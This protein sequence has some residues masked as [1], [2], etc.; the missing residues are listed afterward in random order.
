MRKLFQQSILVGIISVALFLVL[1]SFAIKRGGDSYTISVNGKQ[2]V[3]YFVLSKETLPELKINANSQDKLSVYYS[4]CGKIGTSRKL[5]VRNN[6]GQ[7]IKEWKFA[8]T[9]DE[10]TPMMVNAKEIIVSDNMGLYYES[11]E[12]TTPRKLVNLMLDRQTS[13]NRIK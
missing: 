8:N 7:I 11:K 6:H 9:L 4:E 13:A 2:V 3:Q 12:V 10:H 1:S 5:S